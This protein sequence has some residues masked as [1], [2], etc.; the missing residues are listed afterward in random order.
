MPLV[1]KFAFA[2]LA[3]VALSLAG[4]QTARAD[5]VYLGPAVVQPSGQGVVPTVLTLQHAGN[6]TTEAGA[7]IRGNGTDI[8]TGDAVAGVN[9]KTIAFSGLVNNNG[10]LNA[11][12]LGIYLDIVEPGNDGQL[13]LTS[14]V[15][16]A[17]SNSGAVLGTFNYTGGP[18]NLT[19]TPGSGGGRS[20]HVF[21]L[22]AGQAAQLQA[23]FAANPDLRLG[24]AASFSGVAGGPEQFF[25]GSRGATQQPIP[26]PATMLL[27][28]TGLAGIAAKVRRRRKA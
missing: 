11:A 26:E 28:G 9:S 3:F 14:L 22:T 21:G 12:D 20:D 17:Y 27:L 25:F 10:V 15:L 24:L 8:L 1:R 16:T 13:T 18:L 4:A 7:V 23:A 6:N 2:A 5:V 19:E